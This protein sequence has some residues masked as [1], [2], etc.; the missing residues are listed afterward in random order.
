MCGVVA[1]MLA[2]VPMFVLPMSTFSC[3]PQVGV[4]RLVD[5]LSS[6][7]APLLLFNTLHAYRAFGSGT[8]CDHPLLLLYSRWHTPRQRLVSVAVL[9]VFQR[10]SLHART[11]DCICLASS[12][13]HP[14]ALPPCIIPILP[15]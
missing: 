5:V 1:W 2:V 13:F 6:C 4:C 7:E 12:F 14:I 11:L 8:V 3:L 10:S 9:L 15:T